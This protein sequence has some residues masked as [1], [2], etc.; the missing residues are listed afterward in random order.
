MKKY[1]AYIRVS[2]T[3][4]GEQGS[5]LTE[6]RDAIS[7]CAAKLGIAISGWFEEQETAAKRGRTVFR[8]MLTQLKKGHAAGLIMHKIDRGARNLA[9]WAEIASLMDLGIDVQFAHESIDLQT[10]GGR[11]SADIQ[12]VVAADYI[13]NLRD[14]VKKGIRG[15][16]KQGIYPFSAP[17][18]Y[19]NNGKGALKTIDP[20][21]GPL[22]RETFEKYASG[23]FGLHALCAHMNERGLR[24]SGGRP[25][26]VSGLARMLGNPFYF[27]MIA[28]KGE[29]FVGA[30]EPLITQ[31]LYDQVRAKAAGRLVC[32]TRRWGTKSYRFRQMLTCAQCKVPLRGETQRGHVYYRCHSKGCVGVCLREEAI[33]AKIVSAFRFVHVAPSLI[34]TLRTAFERCEAQRREVEAKQRAGLE[35][36]RTQLEARLDRLTDLLVDGTL[37]RP[38][39]LSRKEV[40]DREALVIGDGLRELD[41]HPD[42][43]GEADAFVSHVQALSKFTEIA[44]PDTANTIV[45]IAISNIWVSGKTLDIQWSKSF[46]ML[47]DLGGF[48]S[49]ALERHAERIWRQIVTG[50]SGAANDSTL[51]A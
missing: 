11:L 46:Q 18:G 13:R 28:V 48:P 30:H 16:L 47:L 17:P 36:R 26:N 15:R 32:T 25:F 43:Q 21:Q 4:Q 14:E 39:Y 49:S 44:S 7:R 3:K 33:V 34:T 45:K 37:E 19:Q 42:G 2:T 35:L 24:N 51:A 29:T 27:G 10:R 38:A 1:Y 40:I 20:V 9:D 12:A 6:Q 5:S 8:K 22:V 23:Y 31:A 50:E 41:A